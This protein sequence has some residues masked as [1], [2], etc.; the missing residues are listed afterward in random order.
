MQGG[1]ALENFG[2]YFGNYLVRW[3]CFYACQQCFT[4]ILIIQQGGMITAKSGP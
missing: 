4:L 2:T 1:H 3:F